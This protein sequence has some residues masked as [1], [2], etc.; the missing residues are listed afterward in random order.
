MKA[1]LFTLG[2]CMSLWTQPASA[3]PF[4]IHAHARAMRELGPTLRIHPVDLDWR[5]PAALPSAIRVRIRVRETHNRWE[6][7]RTEPRMR[8]DSPRALSVVAG[9]PEPS[10]ATL[11][12]V[13][14]LLA[15]QAVP[16]RSRAATPP[17]RLT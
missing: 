15:I 11:F 10:A 12:G 3:V 2:F 14:L 17:P 8:L 16:K 6:N 1:I 9:I 13:G 7:F 4:D 5:S